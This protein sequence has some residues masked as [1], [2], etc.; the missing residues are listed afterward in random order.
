MAT[1]TE[2]C[3]R[4]LIRIG[5]DTIVDITENSKEGRLC[6]ILYDQIRK[7]L[8]RSHPWNFAIRRIILAPDANTAPNTDFFYYLPTL[9]K[10][11]GS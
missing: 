2:I 8:L 7:D 4:A 10:G 1:Q 5:A 11:I 6:N 3:N 9:F